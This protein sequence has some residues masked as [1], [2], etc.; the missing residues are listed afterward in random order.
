MASELGN[1]PWSVFAEGVSVR[2]PL[3]VGTATVATSFALLVL[4]VP[5]RV[6]PGIGTLL[7]AVLVGVAMD[8]TLWLL[9]PATLGV[10]IGARRRHRTRGR[11]QRALPRSGA[12][13]RPAR[14]TPL[15]AVL[16]CPTSTVTTTGSLGAVADEKIRAV[17]EIPKG[18]RNKYELNEET[19]DMEFDRRLFGAVSFP[20]DYGFIRSTRTEEGDPLD[21]LVCVTE[22]T[23]P[24]CV[25]PVNVIALFRMHDE[26]GPDH[27]V[28]GVPAGDPAWCDI[29]DV[30]GLPGDLKDEI[31]HFF[32][33]Y[34][35]LEGQE[36]TIDEWGSGA[37]ARELLEA[38]RRRYAES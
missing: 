30:D 3:S 13:S 33:V 9:G 19:G 37:D 11:G 18:S 15:L 22:P 24:G 36:V 2:T 23:F 7:N 34:T 8:A 31:A 28:V 10:R 4:W 17:V 20:T 29:E 25:V 6:R 14:R 5:L 1:S 32:S 35:D 26:H 27:K 21:V 16:G 12:R 38:C